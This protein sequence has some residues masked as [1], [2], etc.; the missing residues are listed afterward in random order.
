M[1]APWGMAALTALWFG[2]LG[3]KAQS[4]VALWAAAGALLGLVLTT[5]AIGLGEAATIPFSAEQAQVLHAKAVGVAALI[6]LC[7]GA[8]LTLHVWRRSE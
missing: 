5:F 2:M 6:I 8:A 4:T 3:W 1:I 7:L